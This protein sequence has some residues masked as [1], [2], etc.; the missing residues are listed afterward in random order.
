MLSSSASI[1]IPVI[2]VISL[3]SCIAIMFS[4]QCT[5][6]SRRRFR[7]YGVRSLKWWRG[8]NNKLLVCNISPSE[9]SEKVR[10]ALRRTGFSDIEEV[11][12]LITGWS[13]GVWYIMGGKTAC[14]AIIYWT[15]IPESDCFEIFVSVRTRFVDADIKNSRGELL[16]DLSYWL[17]SL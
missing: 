3:I 7:Q 16:E 11:K 12:N 14:Q 4:I 1:S 8:L 9:I 5:L 17:T 10:N 15:S 13:G 6:D 2:M